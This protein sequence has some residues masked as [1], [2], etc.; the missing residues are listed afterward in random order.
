MRK[1]LVVDDTK[2]I[3][4]MLTTCL[5]LQGYEVIQGKDGAEA[6]DLFK[7]NNDLYLAFLDIKMPEISGTEVL[8]RIRAIGINTP[9]IMMTAFATVKNA[10][11]CT[12][13]GVVAYLQKPFTPDKVKNV[14]KEYE[15]IIIENKDEK[16]YIELSNEFLSLGKLEE[17]IEV[18]KKAISLN[19]TNPDVYVNFSRTYEA[20][21]LKDEAE[22]FLKVYEI[23]KR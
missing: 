14:L 12:K 22:K 15:D 1:I 20:Y 8:R 17:S 19:P 10:V 16:Y 2:N 7:D 3:R 11:E 5:E 21:G 4:M 6:L 13:L 18:L 9:V 23:F